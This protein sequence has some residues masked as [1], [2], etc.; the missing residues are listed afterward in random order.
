VSAAPELV[1]LTIAYPFGNKVETFL[2]AEIE[3]L[4][5]RFRRVYVLP[6]HREPGT[7]PLPANAELVEMDWLERP[8]GE[9]P[10]GAL[11][12]RRAGRALAWTLRAGA[13]PRPYLRAPR[14]YLGNLARNVGKARSLARFVAER[15]LG[16]AI[17]YDYWFEN[18]TLALALLRAE[19]TV[20]TAACRVHGFD[21]YDERWE[22]GT[23]PFREAKARGLDA[24]FAV[25]ANGAEYL[26][27][28]LPRLGDKVS[29][30]R[31][32]VRDPGRPCP[33][34]R[35]GE[36]PLVL[37]CAGLTASKRVDLVPE[38]LAALDRPLRWVHLGD[39]AERARVAAAASR[40]LD[41]RVEWELRG[42]VDNSAV[43]D[44]YAGNHVGALLS[45]SSSE[46]LPV[47]M[48]EAQSYG[49]PV[50]ARGVG[51]VAEIVNDATGVLLAPEATPAQAAVALRTA[52]EP[53][54]F[55]P[56]AVR[57]EFQRCFNASVNYNGF[58]DALLALRDGTRPSI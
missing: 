34:P 7:R 49:V 3:V 27:R 12:S 13:D 20:G 56:D 47:S 41:N 40:L 6:S 24:V 22:A 57:A 46:G 30:Q 2:E 55:D 42:H 51:G 10:L 4:A 44:F 28:R 45:L 26:E 5:E 8:A 36:P 23:V 33:P 32:G 14:A 35:S 53:G 1:L 38:V 31:L 52:L 11:A 58:A 25:S 39:G 50:V 15:G 19:R 54:R 43:L 18:S 16:S 29:V 17:F 9:A 37:T 48:M 21:L